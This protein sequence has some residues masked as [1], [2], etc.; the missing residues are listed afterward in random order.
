MQTE[1]SNT[2]VPVTPN[3]EFECTVNGKELTATI[4]HVEDNHVQRLL[5]VSFSDGHKDAYAA[6]DDG[7][8]EQFG[9]TREL[10]IYEE[11]VWDDLA[12]IPGLEDGGGYTYVKVTVKKDGSAFNVWVR[13]KE[14]GD[15]DVY[16]KGEYQFTLRKATGWQVSTKHEKGYVID[17]ELASLVSRHLDKQ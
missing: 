16:Y 9:R 1:L 10:D 12:V 17:Q 13:P 15:Y 14:E 2:I 8:D 11:A 4:T 6:G 5:H 7:V 3:I